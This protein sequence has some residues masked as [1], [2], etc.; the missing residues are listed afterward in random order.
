[1]NESEH[2][3]Q[4]LQAYYESEGITRDA[5]ACKYLNRCPNYR[6]EDLARGMQC[7]IGSEYGKKIRILVASLDSGGGGNATIDERIKTIVD[8]ARGIG[9]PINLHMRGTHQALS[10]FLDEPSKWDHYN[11]AELVQY[12][13]MTNTCKCCRKKSTTQMS[14]KY[15]K[16]CGEHTLAEISIIKPQV[17]LFQGKN[18]WAGCENYLSPIEGIEDVDIKKAVRLFE[19]KDIKCY[20]VL[21]IHPSARFK[22]TQTRIDFYNLILPKIAKYI[23]E[24]LKG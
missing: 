9:N 13:V 7:H 5:F 3:K 24:S 14:R 19:Y 10:Y 4:V 8:Q 15:F 17:I 16:N 2:I 6:D 11:P 22:Y 1:M 21:C 20:A 18:S 23:K 12:M